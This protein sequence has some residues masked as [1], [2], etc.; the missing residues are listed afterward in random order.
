MRAGILGGVGSE[1][2]A[3]R[4]VDRVNGL[5]PKRRGSS[6][7]LAFGLGAGDDRARGPAICRKNIGG[8]SRG[9]SAPTG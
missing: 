1:R 7:P 4:F 6:Q 2:F 8:R 5:E 3:T 9:A